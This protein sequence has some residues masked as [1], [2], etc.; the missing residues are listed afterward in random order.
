M[1]IISKENMKSANTGKKVANQF[2]IDCINSETG[3][4]ETTA[5]QSYESTIAIIDWL[6]NIVYIGND[7]DYSNTT[8]K[9]R[10]QFFS[11]YGVLA[12]STLKDLNKALKCGTFMSN[13]GNLYSIKKIN[14]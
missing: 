5:F 11:N 8:G 7:Y 3:E 10:N 6:N 2:I 13:A 9:Y 1:T 12:L 14:M 4:I